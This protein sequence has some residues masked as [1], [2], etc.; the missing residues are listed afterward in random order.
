MSKRRY[1]PHPAT[2]FLLLTLTVIVL[3]WI[4]DVYGLEMHLSDDNEAVRIQ[5]LL[6]PEG[7]RW[8]LRNAVTNFTGFPPLGMGMT[9]MFGVGVAMHS[10]FADACLRRSGDK[11]RISRKERRSLL[12]ALFTGL[13]YVALILL[14]TFSPLAILRGIDGKLA[15]SPFLESSLFLIAFGIGLVSMVYGF[16]I[17]RYR[18]DGDAINGIRRAF[19]LLQSYIIIS[20]PA[21]QWVACLQYSHLGAYM[22]GILRCDVLWMLLLF[23]MAYYADRSNSSNQ[24]RK[25]GSGGL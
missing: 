12:V 8:M 20:F 10:G 11:R 23:G 16:A 21:A 15:R 7:I 19:P 2:L 3:S 5:S 13:L 18:T 24:G 4:L 9:V 22:G 25:G 1:I 6:N 14:A 17:G